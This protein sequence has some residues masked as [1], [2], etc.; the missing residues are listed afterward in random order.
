MLPSQEARMLAPPR[1]PV[2]PDHRGTTEKSPTSR[3]KLSTESKR[4]KRKDTE[5]DDSEYTP[6]KK[7]RWE[8][9][10]SN[11]ASSKP[12]RR[13]TGYTDD[14]H[15]EPQSGSAA[16]Q[17]TSPST[18]IGRSTTG[19]DRFFSSQPAYFSELGQPSTPESRNISVENS[20]SMPRRTPLLDKQR[21]K[22]KKKQE[23]LRLESMT[24]IA[25][26][27]RQT[28]LNF[29]PTFTAVETRPQNGGSPSMGPYDT[30]PREVADET[31]PPPESDPNIATQAAENEL[32]D[33]FIIA[34]NILEHEHDSVPS[35]TS[36]GTGLAT[37][38][39]AQDDPQPQ[40]T[41]IAIDI[42][43]SIIA[44][45]NPRLVKRN[46]PIQSL[47]GK[48]VRNLFEEVSKFTSK[49]DIQRIVF[50]LNL[51]QA[52]SEYTIQRDDHRTFEAM[53]DD[54]ADDIMADWREN[55][56]TKFS[57]WL[58]PDPME[59]GNQ[60][61]PGASGVLDVNEGRPRITI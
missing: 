54:F 4:G 6:S 39:P 3:T 61:N 28:K 45:R 52:D 24:E 9:G 30:R 19:T 16:D 57:I 59:E 2:T 40:I 14:N 8:E 23:T 13:R 55:G 37:P 7:M 41:N 21:E 36:R 17:F 44:S 18:T 12:R 50:T 33:A 51:S 10:I 26:G 11:I 42:R 58:E 48:T 49:P 46:W 22:K 31:S 60:M 53:K 32:D 34:A 35:Q 15:V 47:S 27:Q 29:S 20:P 1:N 25:R 43:Y 5:D 38:E 56:I